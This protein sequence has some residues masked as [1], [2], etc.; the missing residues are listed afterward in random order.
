M[1]TSPTLVCDGLWGL[2]DSVTATWALTTVQT[3]LLHLIRNTFRYSSRKDWEGLGKL[4]P[5]Y[6]A[7]SAAAA[8]ERFD[9]FAG[10]WGSREPAVIR[11]WRNA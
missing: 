1:R 3:C 5:V 10:T 4:R 11:L 7:P 6:T 8:A 9:E 2:P